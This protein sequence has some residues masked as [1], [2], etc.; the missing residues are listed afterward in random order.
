MIWY[1]S[2][3][4]SQSAQSVRRTEVMATLGGFN[5]RSAVENENAT[6]SPRVV[7]ET[8]VSGMFSSSARG[9]NDRS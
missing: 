5:D 3:A 8:S 9:F 7:V 1:Y 4:D 6:V 2:S